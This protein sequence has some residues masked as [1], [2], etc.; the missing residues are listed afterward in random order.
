MDF[1]GAKNRIAAKIRSKLSPQVARDN[2]IKK[3]L[4]LIKNAQII[5]VGCG[6]QRYKVYC[7]DGYISQDACEYKS[8]KKKIIRGED[9][10]TASASSQY[11]YGTVD[12][13]SNAWSIPVEG[14]SYDA[15][16]CTEVLEHLPYP[17]E[18]INEI[19]RI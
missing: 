19:Y 5:D 1:F 16:L 9:I 12:I 15:A 2:F 17:L 11:D 6:S 3:Q 18:V 13:I 14:D 10:G 7:G 4:K 8:D